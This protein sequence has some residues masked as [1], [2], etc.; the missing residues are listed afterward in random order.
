ML[1]FYRPTAS[2]AA[3]DINALIEEAEALVDKH[4]RQRGV[5]LHNDLSPSCRRCAPRPT[6]SSR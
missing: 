2:M 6:R 5:R 4:L 1:G 3:T